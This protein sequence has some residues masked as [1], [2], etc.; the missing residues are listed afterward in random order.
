[1]DIQNKYQSTKSQL[2]HQSR[3]NTPD[4]LKN[5]FISKRAKSQFVGQSEHL[6]SVQETQ[7]LSD[8]QQL[9]QDF[10]KVRRWNLYAVNT[11]DKESINQKRGKFAFNAKKKQESKSGEYMTDYQLQF[12]NKATAL[13]YQ[14]ENTKKHQQFVTFLQY[15]HYMLLSTYYLAHLETGNLIILLIGLFL[16]ILNQQIKNLDLNL[17]KYLNQIIDII[18]I[19]S[20]SQSVDAN[21]LI[22]NNFCP[23][24]Y[25][26]FTNLF[27]SRSWQEYSKKVLIYEFFRYFLAGEQFQFETHITQ[28]LIF[29][30]I[31]GFIH[32]LLEKSMKDSWVLSDSFMKSYRICSHIL[33]KQCQMIFIVSQKGSL[34][35]NNIQALKFIDENSINPSNI[36]QE[37]LGLDQLKDRFQEGLA[38]E[39]E[40]NQAETI[41]FKDKKLDVKNMKHID[42]KNIKAYMIEIEDQSL[43]KDI[44]FMNGNYASDQD[45]V[46]SEEDNDKSTP[47][48][49]NMNFPQMSHF[50]P[51]RSISENVNMM[52]KLFN[53]TPSSN[54]KT[55]LL[56]LS[57]VGGTNLQQSQSYQDLKSQQIHSNKIQAQSQTKQKMQIPKIK[58]VNQKDLKEKMILRKMNLK[59][60]KWLKNKEIDSITEKIQKLQ[61]KVGNDTDL[62]LKVDI[63]HNDVNEDYQKFKVMLYSLLDGLLCTQNAASKNLQSV[64]ES[65]RHSTVE[66]SLL[67][68]QNNGTQEINSLMIPLNQAKSK[69]GSSSNLGKKHQFKISIYTTKLSPEQQETLDFSLKSNDLAKKI[70]YDSTYSN[71]KIAHQNISKDENQK[72]QFKWSHKQTEKKKLQ[73]NNFVET[74]IHPFYKYTRSIETLLYQDELWVQDSRVFGIESNPQEYKEH[75]HENDQLKDFEV[76]RSWIDETKSPQSHLSTPLQTPGSFY[77]SHRRSIQLERLMSHR[78]LNIAQQLAKLKILIVES[79]ISILFSILEEQGIT[80]IFRAKTTEEALSLYQANWEQAN[81]FDI[82]MVDLHNELQE[83]IDFA[84]DIKEFNEQKQLTGTGMTAISSEVNQIDTPEGYDKVIYKPLSEVATRQSIVF[85]AGKYKLLK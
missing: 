77:N 38:F 61:Q 49:K 27:K 33:D 65:S 8:I 71:V 10:A 32:A 5:S 13:R 73:S 53:Q 7:I 30:G 16:T 83:Y 12:L 9:K 70:V 20:S 78:T 4:E 50:S 56:N 60:F 35:Y 41:L 57:K 24:S 26:I 11:Q 19:V 59:R 75:E 22:I 62:I 31:S 37:F 46:D 47:L 3:S 67:E 52:A 85:A 74:D 68:I 69:I 72:D 58:F 81:K 14:E 54:L 42:Y 25:F 39:K 43:W 2:E 48:S 36:F 51:Q 45:E 64:L 18:F 79:N 15:S 44:D 76:P 17:R 40:I 63:Q 84:K 29:I 21:K 23:Y 28:V 80:Q 1:M 55:P 34:L 82:I 6:Q 66:I